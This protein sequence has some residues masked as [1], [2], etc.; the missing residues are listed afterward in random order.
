MRESYNYTKRKVDA[1]ARAAQEAAMA[2]KENIAK[3]SFEMAGINEKEVTREMLDRMTDFE[4]QESLSEP[5]GT[6]D[7]YVS[8]NFSVVFTHFLLQFYFKIYIFSTLMYSPFEQVSG[9]DD[10]VWLHDAICDIFPTCFR[11]FVAQQHSGN[12]SRRR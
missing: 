10:S 2:A 8:T 3:G 12:P 4:K 9:V 11:V 1:A 7:E 5:K 6:F